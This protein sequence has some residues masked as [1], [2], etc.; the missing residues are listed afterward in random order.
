MS[1]SSAQANTNR[2]PGDVPGMFVELN[3]RALHFLFGAQQIL[4]NEM[5]AAGGEILEDVRSEMHLAAEF[6]AKMGGA[7]SVANIRT[8]LQEC[9]QHQMDVF[10]RDGRNVLRRNQ[11]LA[12]ATSQLFI[13][14]GKPH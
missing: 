6:A 1:D 3:G 14:A 4:L 9:G 5:A 7:H 12:Q 10:S 13:N 8:A 11:R 2:V